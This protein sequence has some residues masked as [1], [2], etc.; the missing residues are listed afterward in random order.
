V[1]GIPEVVTEGE[2]G[3]LVPVRR[4]D[5]L[6]QRMVMLA[7]DGE[8]RRRLG[9]AARERMKAFSMERM[10]ASYEDLY[11]RVLAGAFT[12]APPRVAG[13]AEEGTEVRRE[14][15]AER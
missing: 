1:G 7:G 10:V 5:L 2:T 12:S 15:K 6:A 13:H 4:P 14:R 9:D 8:L 3:Y 11:E